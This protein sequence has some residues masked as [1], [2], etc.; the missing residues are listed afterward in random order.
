MFDTGSA[1]REVLGAGD[2]SVGNGRWALHAGAS[3]RRNGDVRTP[4]GRVANTQSRGGFGNVGLSWTGARGYA[5]GSYG[6][7][8]TRYG[9][10]VVEE[11]QVELTP[12]RHQVALK[13]EA[14]QLG[15]V[16]NGIRAD[17]ASRRYRHEEIVAGEIGTRFENDTD[18]LNLL[19]RHRPAGRLTGTVG[20]WLLHRQFVAEGEEALSPPIRERGAAAFFYEE[21]TWPHVTAQFGARLNHASYEPERDRLSRRFTDT[22][23][24][25]GVVFRPAA[26]DDR[27]T[28]AVNL[29]RA[30]RNPALE[31][32]YFFGPHPGN[33]A[34]EIGNDALGSER[35]LGVDVS[36]RWRAPRVTGE[37]TYFRNAIDDYIYREPLDEADL[38]PGIAAEIDALFGHEGHDDLPFARFVATDSLLQ[39][40]ESHADIPLGGGLRLEVGLD[41]LRGTLRQTGEPLPRM[42]PFRGRAGVNYS[43]NAFRAG[44]EVVAVSRQARVARAE[45]ATAG[46]GLVKLFSSYSFGAAGVT[47][48]I[49][50]R[51]DNATDE[52]YRNH[53]SLIKDFVAEPGRSAKLVYS[54]TF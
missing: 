51:V 40:V 6:Y 36:L 4:E 25:A 53:L 42:P 17:Y 32:L 23:A 12:R 47:H 1:A 24:S 46:Y 38:D 26:A 50:A 19:I 20:G 16:V 45:T 5:G 41:Y 15:G 3:A 37:I 13:A 44:G 8:D 30:S 21:L 49:T 22:S 18:E 33:F 2:L 34:F 29:A 11:G 31:E 9:I 7:D 27:L 48:T 28:L 10:P 35:A 54:V 52:T 14:S 39:G 43:R